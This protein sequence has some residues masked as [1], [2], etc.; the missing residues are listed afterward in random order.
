METY[1]R[2]NWKRRK[3]RANLSQEM[4]RR[5]KVFPPEQPSILRREVRI[6]F[7]A[8]TPTSIMAQGAIKSVD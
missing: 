3:N 1:S 5:G 7:L 8:A 4:S 6:G 2:P